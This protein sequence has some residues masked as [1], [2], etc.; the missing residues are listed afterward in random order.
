MVAWGCGCSG[1]LG[2]GGGCG[3]DEGGGGEWC[4]GSNRSGWEECF[5]GSPE[6]FFGG[7]GSGRKWPAVAGGLPEM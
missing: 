1:G 7:G 6:K 3:R 5:W 2:G 4:G